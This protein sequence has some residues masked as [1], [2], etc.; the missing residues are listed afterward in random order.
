MPE[1]HSWLLAAK[2][3]PTGGPTYRAWMT[4]QKRDGTRHR[5]TGSQVQFG[6]TFSDRAREQFI[7]RYCVTGAARRS[8]SADT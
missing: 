3:I 8:R 1:T 4:R 6:R 5:S 2:V 7:L